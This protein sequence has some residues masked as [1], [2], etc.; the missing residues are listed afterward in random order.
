M[1]R[2]A[3]AAVILCVIGLVVWEGWIVRQSTL[4]PSMVTASPALGSPAPAL[5]ASASAA[6]LASPIAT[7]SPAPTTPSFA[8]KTET[9]TNGD[10]ELHFTN[11][12]GGISE[13]VLPK[14]K[15]EH[16]KT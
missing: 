10:V 13:A 3:W 11:R 7:P 2:T 9:L 15:A 12:G 6:P 1:D 14:H 16:D 8:L 5:A 4:K